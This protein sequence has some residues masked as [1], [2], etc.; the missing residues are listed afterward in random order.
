M[1]NPIPY[2]EISGRPYEIGF[3]IGKSSKITLSVCYRS[4]PNFKSIR[5]YIA[6]NAISFKKW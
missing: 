6:T 5:Q 1:E 2:T 4:F 3:K